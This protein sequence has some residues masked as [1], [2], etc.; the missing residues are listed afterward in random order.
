MSEIVRDCPRL[1]EIAPLGGGRARLATVL[2]AR[3]SRGACTVTRLPSAGPAASRPSRGPSAHSAID[4]RRRA[5]R[6]ARL[7]EVIRVLLETRFG[8]A[9]R[10]AAYGSVVVLAPERAL[11][12]GRGPGREVRKDAYRG[13]PDGVVAAL[14]PLPRAGPLRGDPGALRPTASV[15]SS[16]ST[17]HHLNPKIPAHLSTRPDRRCESVV[18]DQNTNGGGVRMR[19]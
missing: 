19:M 11:R 10:Q 18:V 2:A 15:L 14:H 13:L 5:R 8:G 16:N 4:G 7:P 6:G 17:R 12:R 3:C 9:Q 1:S